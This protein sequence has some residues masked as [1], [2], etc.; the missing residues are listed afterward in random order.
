MVNI[1]TGFDVA[2]AL[3][4]HSTVTPSVKNLTGR[5]PASVRDFLIANK[6]LLAGVTDH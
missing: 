3:G 1:M 2:T 6:A 4:F 5:E